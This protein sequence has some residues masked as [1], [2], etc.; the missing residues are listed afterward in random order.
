MVRGEPTGP[1]HGVPVSFKDTIPT[2][3]VRTTW[4]SALYEQFVPTV[5]ALAVRRTKAAGGIMLGKTN[6]PE[7]AC[8]AATDNRLFG[9]TRNPWDPMRTPG[10]SSGGAAAA[11]AAGMGPLALGSDFAGS[12]RIPAAACGVVGLKPSPGRL[13]NAGGNPWDTISVEGPLARTVRDVALFLEV[14]SGP[15]ERDPLSLPAASFL[16]A[17]D[18]PLGRPRVAWSLDLGYATVDARVAAV[19][20]GAA[21]VFADLG[22]D[23]DEAHPGF[24]DPAGLENRYAAA[25]YA[26]QLEPHL[27]AWAERMDPALLRFI[28]R[29][30]AMPAVEYVRLFDQRATLYRTTAAFFARYDLLLTP[31]IAVP[32]FPIH[33]P[34]SSAVDDRPAAQRGYGWIPFTYPFNLTGNPAISIPAGWTADGLPIGLQ[35]VGPC[36]GEAAVLRAAAA[37]EAARP[38]ADRRPPL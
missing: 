2:A 30:A 14:L 23:V 27:A 18:E 5:D 10:G 17:C 13:P 11:V 22:C 15:D 6:T 34:T 31:T 8:K 1:L 12:V 7:F 24:A 26:A 16:A 33:E 21:H 38:W 25:M 32:P 28:H 3:G 35:I 4:G 20:E 9:V 36:H 37:F 29:G 19:A